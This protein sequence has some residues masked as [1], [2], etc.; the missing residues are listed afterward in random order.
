MATVSG[1]LLDASVTE[2]AGE[3]VSAVARYRVRVSK[4]A[5]GGVFYGAL[6]A[7]GLP[8]PGDTLNDGWPDLKLVGRSIDQVAGLDDSTS[9]VLIFV[10]CEYEIQRSEAGYMLRGGS[11][12]QQITTM[13]D[14]A[15]AAIEVTHNSVTQRGEVQ[16]MV[17]HGSFTWEITEEGDNPESIVS[18]WIGKTNSEEWRGGAA[19]QWL[20]AGVSYELINNA[21]AVGGNR[22]YTF[23]YEL[24]RNP[25]GWDPE[26]AWKDP[27]TGTYPSG[28]VAGTGI[29][30]I[31][32]YPSVA[33]VPKFPDVSGD[34]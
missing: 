1:V 20:V 30:T 13:T 34:V 19:G 5:T 17:P 12:L 4:S 16:V 9:E 15:G 31:E 26:I 24:E 27:D 33:F 25:A 21:E 28:L 22:K 2:R 14:S 11:S 32:Y 8:Q 3:I 10:G 7:D 6:N 23:S 18:Y 29:K